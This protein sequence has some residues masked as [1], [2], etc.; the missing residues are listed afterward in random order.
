MSAM[1]A[2]AKAQMSFEFMLFTTVSAVGLLYAVNLFAHSRSAMSSQ[3]DAA[4]MAYF[5]ATLNSQMAYQSSV[6]S[7]YVPIGLCNSSV[8]G[9]SI[10]T[11]YGDFTLNWP[12]YVPVGICQYSGSERELSMNRD[13]NGT[14]ILGVVA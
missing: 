12:L 7:A 14:Y 2:A 8:S 1:P 13:L 3:D 10:S 4:S 9:Y 5:I 6:F 11:A